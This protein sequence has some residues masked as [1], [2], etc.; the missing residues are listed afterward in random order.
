V[1]RSRS[2]K[3]STGM[4]QLL[5]AEAEVIESITAATVPGAPENFQGMV[6]LHGELW[7]AVAPVAISAGAQVRVVSVT[8]LTVHVMP[9]G[10]AAR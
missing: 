6:R 9:A 10:S 5:G 8:G 7:R 4:Q 2:W 1:L 3:Q